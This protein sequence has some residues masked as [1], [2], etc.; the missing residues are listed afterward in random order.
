MTRAVKRFQKKYDIFSA[1]DERYGTVEVETKKMLEKLFG[2][3]PIFL[4]EVHRLSEEGPRLRRPR[5][6]TVRP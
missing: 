3:T 1:D 6:V 4:R 5:K 2:Q